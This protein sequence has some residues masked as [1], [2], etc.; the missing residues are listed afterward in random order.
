M[1][2]GWRI[3]AAAL[4]AATVMLCGFGSALR[5]ALAGDDEDEA[6]VILFS[7]RD[8]WRNGVFLYGGLLAAPSGFE[9]DGLMFKLVYSSG[10]YRYNAGSLGGARVV[11]FEALGAVMPGFRIKRGPVEMKVFFGPEL[12]YHYL[13]PNDP[14]NRLHGRQFGLRFA[15]ELWAEPT[16]ATMVA[17]DVAFSTIVSNYSGR[18]AFGWKMFDMF[19]AGPESQVYGGDGYAQW[20]FG[21]HVTSLKTGETT[22]WSAAG[23][24]AIDTDRRASAY[25][26][27]GLLQRMN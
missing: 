1:D 8:L 23:G 5:P 10:L 11:G 9:R 15:A 20:R 13:S 6:H 18:I 14:D 21:A 19:Y 4:S 27:L 17:A 12:Q 22:E 16:D 26:R 3:R 7:G 2:R 25:L 24:L